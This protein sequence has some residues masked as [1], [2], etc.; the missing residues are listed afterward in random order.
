MRPSEVNFGYVRGV[1]VNDFS[2]SG[3]SSY[4]F[5]KRIIFLII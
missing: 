4:L 5:C 2:S 1:K 3:I